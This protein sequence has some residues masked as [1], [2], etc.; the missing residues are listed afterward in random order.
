VQDVLSAQ[1]RAMDQA[2]D[3]L[4]QRH[5]AA[6]A[7]MASEAA[8]TRAQVTELKQWFEANQVGWLTRSGTGLNA[9]FAGHACNRCTCSIL[10]LHTAGSHMEHCAMFKQHGAMLC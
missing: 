7:K 4:Q 5:E 2:L 9:H 3:Q 10:L 8:A 6:S 1:I